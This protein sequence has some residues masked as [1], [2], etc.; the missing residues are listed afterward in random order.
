MNREQIKQRE[1]AYSCSN[2]V[3]AVCGKPLNEG[4]PQYAHRI[5]NTKTNRTKYGTFIIDNPMNGVYVC[6][7]RCNQ[8]VNIAFDKGAVLKLIADITMFEIRKFV[9]NG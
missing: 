8:S 7:L 4:Q 5:A 2:G 1:V 3:C 9:N 6:S